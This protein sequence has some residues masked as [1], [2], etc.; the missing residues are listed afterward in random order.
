MVFWDSLLPFV[1]QLEER[2]WRFP[3]LPVFWTNDTPP[4]RR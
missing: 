1:F 3:W 2:W 4:P